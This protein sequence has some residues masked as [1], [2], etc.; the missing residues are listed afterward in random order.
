MKVTQALVLA[1]L[2]FQA[3]A[4][5]NTNKQYNTQVSDGGDGE[6]GGDQS[7]D[8]SKNGGDGPKAEAG[9]GGNSGPANG[10]QGSNFNLSADHQTTGGAAGSNANTFTPGCYGSCVYTVSQDA[11][12]ANGG[13]ATDNGVVSVQGNIANTDS[14][15]G[16]STAGNGGDADATG[17]AGDGTQVANSEGGDG[18]DGNKDGTVQGGD[19]KNSDQLTVPVDVG[20][21]IPGLRLRR[22]APG[23]YAERDTGYESE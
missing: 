15:G 17:D 5:L 12:G 22:Y 20:P 4:F 13:A 10:G 2:A 23:A 7:Q 19:Q 18:G 11:I 8:G 9:N 1:V 16:Q 14:S 3:N 6:K 21:K